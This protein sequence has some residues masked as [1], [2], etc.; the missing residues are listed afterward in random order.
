MAAK[1][2]DLFFDPI[3][4][5]QATGPNGH[6]V[7]EECRDIPLWVIEVVKEK[8]QRGAVDPRTVLHIPYGIQ[9]TVGEFML[10]FP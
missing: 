3:G 1:V 9:M 4:T 10:R 6:K 8:V 2:A 7:P 5:Y